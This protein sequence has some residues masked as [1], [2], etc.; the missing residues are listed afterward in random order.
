M[1]E[2]D[3]PE[4]QPLDTSS[5]AKSAPLP[6]DLEDRVVA[7]LRG[8][9]LIRDRPPTRWWIAAVAAL[10]LFAAGFALGRQRTGDKFTFILLLHEG[11][12]WREAA[13]PSEGAQR[14]TE[15]KAWA[16]R[17]RAR[18]L[19]IDGTELGDQVDTL[20][21]NASVASSDKIGGFFAIHAGN[22]EE[23]KAIARTCP[24]LSHGGQIE[25]RKIEGT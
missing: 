6:H 2:N 25:I 4:I 21:E 20:S 22:L 13:S 19:Q 9:R 10:A 24:H 8:R 1:E 18:G 7:A 12:G 5:L 3:V 14:V 23:A 15:Y 17:L 16:S 11:P